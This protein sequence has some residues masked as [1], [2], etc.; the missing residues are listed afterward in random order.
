MRCLA[1]LALV[2]ALLSGGCSRSFTAADAETRIVFRVG[3]PD[4]P[5]DHSAILP[6][7][8]EIVEQRLRSGPLAS[9]FLVEVQA[10]DELV[11]LT[12]KLTDAQF[13]DVKE[14][15]TRPGML[16]FALL[17]NSRD[18][19]QL[20]NDA[21]SGDA[22]PDAAAPQFAWIPFKLDQHGR[23][24]EIN[25]VG[26]MTV[27]ETEAAGQS[28]KEALVVLDRPDRRITD[29]RLQSVTAERGGS[30][31]NIRPALGFTLD[32]TGGALLSRL[33]ASATGGFKRRLAVILDGRLHSAPTIN[34]SIAG[35]GIIEG[36]FS[37]TEIDRIVICVN[38]GRL[39]APV[40]FVESQ[41]VRAEE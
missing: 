33:T 37:Q 10:P 23:S 15:V 36:A 34:D 11:V 2:L 7:L 29:E 5:A 3:D 14:L 19:A 30:E 6:A 32:S 18:H 4:A 27:R 28:Y 41:N 25:D 22:Q 40:R 39:P 1:K 35:R 9:R 31:P 38:S 24:I 20:I 17:A 16:E 8:K 26:T 21:M 13:A 12:P